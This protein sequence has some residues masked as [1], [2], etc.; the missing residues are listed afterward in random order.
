[1]KTAAQHDSM[2]LLMQSTTLHCHL[3]I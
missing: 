1:M 2:I 3:N